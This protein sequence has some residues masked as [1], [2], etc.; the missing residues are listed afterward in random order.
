MDIFVGTVGFVGM[1]F[2][3]GLLDIA[4]AKYQYRSELTGF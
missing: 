1:I 4:I 2:V 3:V